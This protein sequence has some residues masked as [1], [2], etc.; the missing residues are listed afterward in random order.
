LKKK[1]RVQDKDAKLMMKG[2][3]ESNEF[4]TSELTKN[5]VDA[6]P[7]QEIPDVSTAHQHVA[8]PEI[9]PTAKQMDEMDDTEELS[10]Y[11]KS[12]KHV[13]SRLKE[14]N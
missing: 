11:E 2:I 8:K 12:L 5:Y 14:I 7:G 3:M 13:L 1:Y 4:G 6:T 9:A 10:T